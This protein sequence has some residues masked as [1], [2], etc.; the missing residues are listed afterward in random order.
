MHPTVGIHSPPTPEKFKPLIIRNSPSPSHPS[1]SVCS[2]AEHCQAKHV[3]A[4][5]CV[6]KLRMCREIIIPVKLSRRVS[7][8]SRAQPCTFPGLARTRSLG[9]TAG[10][11]GQGRTCPQR[12]LD[13]A[14]HVPRG[15]W[16]EQDTFLKEQDASVQAPA[17]GAPCGTQNYRQVLH[18]HCI[19]SPDMSKPDLIRA[20]LKQ[21]NIPTLPCARHNG[22][23]RHKHFLSALSNKCS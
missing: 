21:P 3:T 17:P 22:A 15:A 18:S 8:R 16:T 12:S 23:V 1:R 14:G 11:P 10:Q 7:P 13:R 4:D 20:N 2:T 9:H 6:V 5:G 19:R